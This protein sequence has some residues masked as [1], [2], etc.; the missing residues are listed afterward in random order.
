MMRILSQNSM[1][2]EN[3]KRSKIGQIALMT[4]FYYFKYFLLLAILETM[5]R[6]EYSYSL[7][8]MLPPFVSA[9]AR[10][11]YF[12]SL[13]MTFCINPTTFSNGRLSNISS[14]IFLINLNT[15]RAL[16]VSILLIRAHQISSPNPSLRQ[17]SNTIKPQQ[18]KA[19]SA[20]NA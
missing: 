3:Q 14:T 5:F 7:P 13:S 9:E 12:I 19:Y 1:L 20:V 8:W 11:N 16:E 15:H 2:Q 4:Y 6:Q 18:G 10:P 17:F